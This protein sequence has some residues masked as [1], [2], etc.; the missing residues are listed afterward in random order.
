MAMSNFN[1]RLITS[2]CL[3]VAFAGIFLLRAWVVNVGMYVFDAVALVATA[4]GIWE[5]CNAKQLN[6]R[7]AN[8]YVAWIVCGLIY[9]FYI[10]GAAILSPHLPWWLQLLVSLMIIGIFVLFIGLSNL[11]D[12]KMAKECALQKKD[13]NSEAW[14]G[15]WDLLQMIIYPGA[16]FAC[17]IILNHMTEHHLGLLGLLLI[18]FT[19]CLSDTLAYTAGMILGRGA[20]KMAPKISPNKTWVGFVGSLFGGVLGALIV[21]WIISADKVAADYLIQKFGDAVMVQL[22][23]AIIGLISAFVTAMGDLFASY[24]KRKANIKDFSHILPGH[25]GVLDRFDGIIFN[26]PFILLIMGII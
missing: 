7:G 17:A 20:A 22:C 4:I 26:V 10:I 24:I 1:K 5:L 19:S 3:V 14:G 23:F 11:L 13:F 2:I 9:F 18:V 6:R 21:V 16:L 15:A 8:A 25:G 12:K